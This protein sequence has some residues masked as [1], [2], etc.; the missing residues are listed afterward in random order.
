MLV[1]QFFVQE[2]SVFIGE[3]VLLEEVLV[4]H[5]DLVLV[6]LLEGADVCLS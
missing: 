3:V 4:E 2:G 6:E 5:L 1:V